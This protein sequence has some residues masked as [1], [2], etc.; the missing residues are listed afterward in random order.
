[1]SGS[2]CASS[3]EGNDTDC[4]GSV[5]LISPLTTQPQHVDGSVLDWTAPVT[6][7]PL[8]GEGRGA[9]WSVADSGPLFWRCWQQGTSGVNLSPWPFF[10]E[11]IPSVNDE[12]FF[13]GG[14]VPAYIR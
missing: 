14:G 6:W 3:V 7:R 1:M 9:A 10:S 13:L 2:Q 4:S 8:P 11:V 12:G 5:G